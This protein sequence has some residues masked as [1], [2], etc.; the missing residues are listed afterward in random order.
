MYGNKKDKK[1][2]KHSDVTAELSESLSQEVGRFLDGNNLPIYVVDP[3]SFEV[4]Y[5][6]RAI[7]KYLSQPPV[8]KLC[9]Q[10]MRGKDSPCERCVAMELYKN[11]VSVPREYQHKEDVWLYLQTSSLTWHEREFIQITCMDIS[12]QKLLEKELLL[13]N[14][15]YGAM[16]RQSHTGMM[17]YHIGEDSA[18]INVDRN[19]N[20][21]EE[22]TIFHYSE[23]ICSSELVVPESVPVLQRLLEDVRAGR[24]GEPCHIQ[25][26]IPSLGKRWYEVCYSFVDEESGHPNRAVFSFFDNTQKQEQELEY[27]KWNARLNA[28]TSEYA[29]YMEANLTKNLV[30]MDKRTVPQHQK[31]SGRCFSE[32]IEKTSRTAVFEEDRIKFRMFYNRERLLGQFCEGNGQGVLEYRLLSTDGPKWY[33][34]ELQ[35]IREPSSE[36]IKVII[37]LT[38]VDEDVAEKVRLKREAE[39]DSMTG[40]YNYAAVVNMIDA[41]LGQNGGEKCCLL[42]VDLDDLREVNGRLGHPEGDR[43]LRAIAD[44]MKSKFRK[45]DILGR[46]GGDEFVAFLRNVKDE[47]GLTATLSRFIQTLNEQRIG[48]QNE[49]PV[50]ASV[51]AVIGTAGKDSFK[52]LYAK[53][54][55][56]LYY[57]KATGKNGFHFYRP[58]LEKRDFSYEYNSVATLEKAIQEESRDLEVVLQAL[59]LFCPLVILANLTKNVYR[60]MEYTSY[61]T[62]R[63]REEGAF[64]LLIEKGAETFHSDDKESFRNCFNRQNLLCAFETGCRMVEHLGRQL[65]DD[66][67]YRK[68]HTV[69][70][71]IQDEENGDIYDITFAHFVSE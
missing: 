16:M 67:V 26:D 2:W 14:K 43:A 40:L 10:V 31:A 61:K 59:S 56:A 48:S 13:R 15:E 3:E 64:D 45:S 39:Q 62:Q 52:T 19:M 42:I 58:E 44:C 4:M 25:L 22:Y 35:M 46:I 66:G 7:M 71:L 24:K 12:R 51:G 57:T 21:V 30:E 20:R 29:V 53:A 9:Y 60:M 32:V 65:G 18:L 33:K 8:G 28:M 17:R 70:I 37:L 23:I 69:V 47:A 68:V 1:D 49:R 50:E 38:N 54:D 27:E 5:A 63:V 41:A 36:D 34:S 6:N 11:G 55:L